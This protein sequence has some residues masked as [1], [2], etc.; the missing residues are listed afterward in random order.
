[1][2]EICISDFTCALMQKGLLRQGRLYFTE[3]FVCFHS[4]I[5]NTKFVV[6]VSEI[7]NVIPRNT[8]MF[9]TALDLETRDGK[10][11]HLKSFLFR[12]TI[13]V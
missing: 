8:L 5:A 4:P 10:S 2:E 13:V 7:L 12:G 9:P 3:E 1:V 6:H 11:F